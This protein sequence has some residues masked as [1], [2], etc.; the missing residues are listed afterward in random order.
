MQ[1]KLGIPTSSL[2]GI[3]Y[4]HVAA[5]HIREDGYY[6]FPFNQDFGTR[7]GS[8]TIRIVGDANHCIACIRQRQGI[9]M[10]CRAG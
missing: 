2:H 1:Y 10:P 5:L 9:P 6:S 7:G 8:E 4:H 3:K